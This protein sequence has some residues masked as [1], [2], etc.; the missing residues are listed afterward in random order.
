MTTEINDPKTKPDPPEDDREKRSALGQFGQN[1]IELPRAFRDSVIRH[2]RPTSDRTRSQVVFGNF[3]LHILPT[4]VHRYSLKMRATLGLGVISMVLFLLLTATG[5]ALMIYYKPSTDQAYDSMK[6]IQYVVPTGRFVRNIHRWS[7]HA[8]VVC[9]ILHMTRAFY[10]AAYKKPREFNWV[11]G[12]MLFVLTLALSFTGYLLPWDQLAFW[13]VTIGSEIAQSPREITDALGITSWMDIGGF[14]KRLILG[15]NHVGQ[16]ALIRFYVLHVMVLPILMGIFLGVH[17]WRIRKD[18]G[19]TRP[20]SADEPPGGLQHNGSTPQMAPSK[21]Y[22]LMAVV[23]SKTPVVNRSMENTI[24]TFPNALYGIAALSM[25]TLAVTL[26]LGYYFDAPLTEQ[27]NPSVPENPAK[28]PWYFLGLQELVSYSAFTGGVAIPAIV[29]LGLMLIPYLDREQ[30]NVGVWFGGPKGKLICLASAV[31]AAATVIGML[32]FTV[33]QGWIRNWYPEISQIVITIINPGTV[34]LALFVIWSMLIK[35]VTNST[36][37]GALA[38]F[39]CFLVAFIILSYFASVHR[40]PNWDFY[41]SM[42]DW[43]LH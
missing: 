3:F 27:A 17:F 35:K 39:T 15:A 30:D 1:L 36:R 22:G 23:R 37:M 2:G 6:E 14:Q 16:E 31:F 38:T 32:V 28:A 11:V 41:W 26:A 13:A 29:V 24:P 43:P 19:I 34:L 8:M 25:V 4:R 18:G 9:V 12:M 20:A 21:T 42:D 40:G 7:A 10:T 33:Q 5:V